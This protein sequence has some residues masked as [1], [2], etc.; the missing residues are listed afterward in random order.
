MKCARLKEQCKWLEGGGLGLVVD[1][2]KDKAKEGATSPQGGEK[3]KKKKTVA[4]VGNGDD[5]IIEV[6]GPSGQWSGF[7]PGLFLE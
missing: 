3:R 5:D 2:A 6:P 1:K 4:K 7:D